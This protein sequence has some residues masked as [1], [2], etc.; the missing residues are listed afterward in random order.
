MR[1]KTHY[2]AISKR[3]LESLIKLADSALSPGASTEVES[4]DTMLPHTSEEL[5]LF[6]EGFEKQIQ[7]ELL[8][9]VWFG[10][11]EAL[12]TEW[13]DFL[14]DAKRAWT[15]ATAS[16]LAAMPELK[17]YIGHALANIEFPDSAIEGPNLDDIEVDRAP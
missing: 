6:I 4:A 10:R 1:M 17:Q 13:Q 12:L 7:I 14:N 15:H 2:L 8:A 11:E 9:L 3:T 16:Y 5:R